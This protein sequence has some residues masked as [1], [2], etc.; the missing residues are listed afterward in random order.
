MAGKSRYKNLSP[1]EFKQKISALRSLLETCSVC[2]HL[3][4]IDR[5]KGEVGFCGAGDMLKIA[6]WSPHF[7]EEDVLV[8]THGSGTIFFSYCNLRCEYCQNYTISQGLEGRDVSPNELAQ[9]MLNL[10]GKGCHNIKTLKPPKLSPY[11]T[12]KSGL[13]LLRE[14]FPIFRRIQSK[15]N[16]RIILSYTKGMLNF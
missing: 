11:F 3:C 7:G 4:K 8:G 5:L 12:E 15:N 2:P 1:G 10:Q 14:Y 16:S 9:I 6:G 13:I